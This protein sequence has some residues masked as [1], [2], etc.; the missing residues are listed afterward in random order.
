MK[1]NRYVVG[2]TWVIRKGNNFPRDP[3]FEARCIY[4]PFLLNVLLDS[5]CV[6]NLL[7]CVD[8]TIYNWIAFLHPQMSPTCHQNHEWLYEACRKREMPDLVTEVFIHCSSDWETKSRFISWGFCERVS[9]HMFLS[10]R[11]KLKL[12]SLTL[13]WR[14]N[15]M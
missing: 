6:R 3:A 1:Q 11:H 8:D 9:K 5:Q 2:E 7:M 15:T 4:T 13:R 14:S 12:M 10:C